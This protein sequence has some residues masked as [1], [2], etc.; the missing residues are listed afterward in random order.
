MG[1]KPLKKSLPHK[2]WKMGL[3]FSFIGNVFTIN[4]IGVIVNF[5]IN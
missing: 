4:T 1:Q 2:G 5:V 3:V